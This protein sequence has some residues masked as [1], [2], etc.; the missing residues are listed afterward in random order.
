MAYRIRFILSQK[1]DINL[2]ILSK[3]IEIFKGGKI[4]GHH[5]KD[6]YMYIVSGIKNINLIYNY[7]DNNINYFL[8]IKKDSYLKFKKI[9]LDIINKKHLNNE[10]RLEL[11]KL[12]NKV[13]NIKRKIK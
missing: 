4:E 2:P 9:N 3:L 12:S 6:N 13:N 10:N 5:K 7:F 8:G 1:G 11:I